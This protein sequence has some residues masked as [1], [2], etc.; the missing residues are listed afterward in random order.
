LNER[1]VSTRHIHSFRGKTGT[2]PVFPKRFLST[3][4][5]RILWQE[6]RHSS[7]LSILPAP[8]NSVF[9][10]IWFSADLPEP[11]FD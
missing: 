2:S 6:A 3:R 5:K 10:A 9:A 11:V 1:P 7:L 4:H 8:V